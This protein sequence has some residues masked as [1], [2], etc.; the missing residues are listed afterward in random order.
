MRIAVTGAS[1]RIGGDVVRLL[2]ADQAHQ[3]VALTRRPPAAGS[4]PDSVENRRADYADEEALAAALDGVGTLVLV[5]S[6]GPVADV[7]VHHRNVIRAAARA[8]AGHIVAMSGLDADLASPFCY[9]AGYGYTEQLLAESG[10]AITLARAS[11]YTEFFLSFLTAARTS[12]QLR[13]PAA[14]ARVSLVSRDDVARALAALAAA[15]PAARPQEITGPEALDMAALA[16]LAQ[17]EWGTP[18]AY[19]A[20]TGGE[21]VTDLAAAGEDPWWIYAF[22]S[23]FASIRD[24]RWKSVSADTERLTGIPP[25]PVRAVLARPWPAGPLTGSRGGGS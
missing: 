2:A 13:V 18:V 19:T 10:C 16:A 8:G 14:D 9:A 5:S 4:W 22:S 25:T 6:D 7:I 20:I 1:G 24:H 3:V 11:I 17:Q 15:G 23:M 12:G 21:L